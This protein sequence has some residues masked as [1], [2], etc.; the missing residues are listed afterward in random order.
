[1]AVD[2]NIYAIYFDSDFICIEYI[3]ILIYFY[4]I[5]IIVNIT[6]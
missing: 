2:A 6:K 3:L 4:I 5:D 1:M